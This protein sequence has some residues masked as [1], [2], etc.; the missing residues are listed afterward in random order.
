MHVIRIDEDVMQRLQSLAID[1]DLVFGSPN[2]VLK[3]VLEINDNRARALVSCNNLPKAERRRTRRRPTASGS[4]LLRDHVANGEID[5]GVQLGYY[6]LRGRTYSKSFYEAREFPV[7][8]FDADGY[9]VISSPQE[10]DEN[11]AISIA[12]NINVINNIENLPGYIRCSHS[13][14][15]LFEMQGA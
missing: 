15:R 10:V 4:V 3:H 1:L 14:N 12:A 9:V 2:D 13:H 8:L 7:V 5:A 6:H 11:P